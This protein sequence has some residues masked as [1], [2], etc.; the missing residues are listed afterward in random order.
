[1]S[2]KL[3]PVKPK[4]LARVLEKKGWELN[5]VTGSH[6]IFEHPSTRATISVPIHNRDM[7][8]G[9]LNRILKDAGIS[10]D[11]LQRLL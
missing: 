7:K 8:T 1:V 9:T 11:E 4:R 5:R 3:P 10:R 6:H 2:P